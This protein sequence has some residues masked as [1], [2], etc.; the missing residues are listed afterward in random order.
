MAV[1]STSSPLT[2]FFRPIRL[3]QQLVAGSHFQ[4]P[5]LAHITG[6]ACAQWEN[7]FETIGAL[8][9]ERVIFHGDH[10]NRFTFFKTMSATMKMDGHAGTVL[11]R[12]PLLRFR[13][14]ERIKNLKFLF[15]QSQTASRFQFRPDFFRHR[16]NFIPC[17]RDQQR[18]FIFRHGFQI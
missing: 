6:Y 8:N 10:C 12:I 7:V 11:S 2:K 9:F 17:R 1:T 13:P 4:F 5:F 14:R 15:F 3:Q 16:F 18:G